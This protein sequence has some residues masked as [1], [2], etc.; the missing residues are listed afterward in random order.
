MSEE[1]G[2]WT[3]GFS[4]KLMLQGMDGSEVVQMDPPAEQ[5]TPSS[6]MFSRIFLDGPRSCTKVNN[7]FCAL[8]SVSASATDT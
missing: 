3:R 8:S 7:F 2:V 1:V 6:P 5:G 4:N